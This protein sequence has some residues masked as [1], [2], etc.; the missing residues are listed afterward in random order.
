MKK[1]LLPLLAV[2]SMAFNAQAAD[3]VAAKAFVDTVASQVL[4]VVKDSGMSKDAKEAKLESIFSDKVDIDF[5]AKFV[6]AKNWRA[7]TPA[8][9]QAYLAAYKPFILKNYASR[10]TKYSGQTYTLKNQR[11]DGD[12]A[13]VTMEI[14]DPNGQ[15]VD[16]DYRLRDE[17]GGKFRVVDIVVEGV[18]L[19]TTQRSEFSS[20]VDAHGMDYLTDR[21]KQ[22]V[23]A[24]SPQ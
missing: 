3:P 19:L 16:V 21:L 18:S 12:A 2:L 17:G 7:A 9:Q 24:Q 6:L 14:I 23:A 22:Q 8:Q 1:F 20:I 10:L 11:D 4:T 5:I 15:N 13:V